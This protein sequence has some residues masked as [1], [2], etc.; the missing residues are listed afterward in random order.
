[1]DLSII[2]VHYNTPKLLY[3]CVYS[4]N[5][6]NTK[7][8]Y[9][10]LII[11]NNSKNKNEYELTSNF[12]SVKWINNEYNAGFS[13][14]NNI[15]IKNSSGK[16]ILFLNPDTKINKGFLDKYIQSYNEINSKK[17][18][19]L[20]TCRIIAI[21]DQSL[22]IGSKLGFPNIRTIIKANP[23]IIYLRRKISIK[24]TSNYDPYIKHYMTHEI[25][26]ASGACFMIS[27]SKIIDNDL[28]FDEDFFLYS[29]DVELSY[30]VKKKGMINYFLGDIEVFHIN[31]ASTSTF[32]NIDIQKYASEL[33]F[34]IKAYGKTKFKIICFLIRLNLNLN[35]YLHRKNKLFDSLKNFKLQKIQLNKYSKVICSKF[36]SNSSSS[37]R[38]LKVNE[39]E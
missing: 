12:K 30:R 13:R 9:E 17:N 16:R 20:L 10:I 38:F 34:Y 2:I 27:K 29:E 32:N 28:F 5:N 35:I 11:D 39:Y 8:S 33:L 1:M 24:K 19:G 31:S 4:I 23:F 36:S 15:G 3:N 25:D 21:K 26:I 22:L 7:I 37:V 18:L 6:S 14:A